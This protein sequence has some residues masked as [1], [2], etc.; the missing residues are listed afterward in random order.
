MNSEARIA[1]PPEEQ[2]RRREVVSSAAWAAEMEGLGKPDPAFIV[3]DELWISGQISREERM[4]RAHA[5]LRALA[6]RV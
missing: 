1:L 3:L 4:N 5:M 6:K 2:A